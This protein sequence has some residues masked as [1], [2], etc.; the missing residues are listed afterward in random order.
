MA[1]WTFLLL[2]EL[3]CPAAMILFGRGLITY[4]Q[5]GHSESP[6]HIRC[7]KLWRR[8]GWIMLAV[9]LLV[10]LLLLGR[11]TV[12]IGVWSGVLIGFQLLTLLISVLPAKRA[13]LREGGGF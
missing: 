6:L 9:T 13:L 10:Q 2:C 3:L 4:S 12:E 1:L 5:E 8:V 11:G 7:G